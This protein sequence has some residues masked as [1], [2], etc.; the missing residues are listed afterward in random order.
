MSPILIVYLIFINKNLKFEWIYFLFLIYLVGQFTGYLINPLELPYHIND[1]NQIYWLICNFTVFLYFYIIRDDKNFNILIL[2]LFIFTISIIAAKFI[3]DVYVEFFKNINDT[4]R[5]VNFFYN[6]YSMSPNK[7]FF[8]QPVPR[9]SGLSRMTVIIFLFLYIQLFF[10]KHEKNKTIYIIIISFLILTILN[11]Q[12]RVSN[13]YIIILFLFTFLFQISNLSFKKKIIYILFIFI[14]PLFIHLNLAQ[15]TLVITKIYKNLTSDKVKEIVIVE[16]DISNKKSNILKLEEQ[17]SSILNNLKKQ[18]ILI[19]SSTGRKDL[20]IDA[21]NWSH[22]N[23][24]MGY[25]PQADR[26]F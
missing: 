2:K 5:V 7:L 23:K 8:E 19:K 13:Y 4:G 22:S 20:W 11:L 9:S 16:E 17:D 25:G 24:F 14:I 1:Q 3:F 10:L 18:R 21:I 26:F 15:G 6:L 12:N